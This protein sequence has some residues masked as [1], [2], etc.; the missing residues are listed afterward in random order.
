MLAPPPPR[1][2]A[3]PTGNPGSAPVQMH[4][5]P[6]KIEHLISGIFIFKSSKR[7]LFVSVL[8]VGNEVQCTSVLSGARYMWFVRVH[9]TV[10]NQ[11]HSAA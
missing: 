4:L 2:G 3:P 5:K 6:K 7:K 8:N 11:L 10:G 1:V 9:F